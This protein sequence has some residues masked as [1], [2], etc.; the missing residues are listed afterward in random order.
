MILA[1]DT[2]EVQNEQEVSQATLAL[3]EVQGE[4]EDALIGLIGLTDLT[5]LTGALGVW[6]GCSETLAF[7]ER[8]GRRLHG[9]SLITPRPRAAPTSHL[10]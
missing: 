1:A 2:L 8:A 10:P 4:F 5:D 6:Q 9:F 3:R 7:D